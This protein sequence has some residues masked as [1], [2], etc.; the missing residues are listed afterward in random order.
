MKRFTSYATFFCVLLIAGSVF[1][2]G[3][4][5]T[6]I[7]A[8]AT[9]LGGNYRA[10]SNDWSAMFWNPAGLSQIQ[11]FHIGGSFELITPTSKV[12][13]APYALPFAVYKT[14]EFKNEPKTFPIPAAGF[15]YGAEK[16]SFGLSVFAPFGLGAKWD[17]MN[18]AAYNPDYPE[19]DF[20][21][22]LQVIDIHPTF[23]YQVSDKLS[24]G[25]GGSVVLTNIMIRKPTT[26]PNPLLADP[27]YAPL[28]VGVLKPLGLDQPIYNYI[29]T[30]TKLEGDGIGFGFNLG[31]KYN[32]TE[33]L[34]LG[35]SGNYY[36]DVSLDGKISATTYFAKADQTKFATLQGTLNTMVQQGMLS[37]A[38]AQQILGIYSGQKQVRYDNAK[39]DATLP[40]PMTLGAGL[41]F[42]GV[43]NLLLSADV[44]WTQWS[45]W[46]VIPIE[47]E[48]G[49]K[50]ELV[51]NWKDGIRVGLGAEY[52]LLPSL[53]LRAGYYTEPSAIPDETLTITIPDISRRH[54][55]N[56]GA[57]YHL[58]PL[59]VFASYEKIFIGDR[60][61]SSWVMTQDKTGFD[62]MA[63][64]YKMDVNN[65]M[66]GL[67]YNF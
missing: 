22:D 32:L 17:A 60:I 25:L 50:M 40:L 8:R 21:D 38:Q 11:G 41:A 24:V 58:G 3:V 37:A 52:T 42:S 30:E 46:D 51:E 44:S 5:L 12:T 66:F 55:L 29:L 63:G 35:L 43:E 28:K 31:L 54:A 26:T 49:T 2:S 67:G 16:M 13:L 10:I 64:T 18:T 4:A 14:E 33:C 36:N 23:A 6:G 47:M 39:G 48:D 56:F 9:A 45:A 53:K 62:N 19:F 61:V 65:F 20:E 27:N 7:G 34:S 57:S 59:S 15:V 1:A